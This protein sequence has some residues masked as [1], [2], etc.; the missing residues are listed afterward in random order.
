[1]FLFLWQFLLPLILFVVA[2]WKI[3]G[4]VRRQGKVATRRRATVSMQPV[5]EADGGKTE[6]PEDG[7]DKDEGVNSGSA[8]AG[9]T[10]RSQVCSQRKSSKTLSKTQINVVSTMVN[11]TIGFTVCWMPTY[12]CFIIWTLKVS[13]IPAESCVTVIAYRKHFLCIKQHTNRDTPVDE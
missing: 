7:I 2:Y 5:A 10:G 1:M 4:V 9:L 6:M 13:W 3:W 12:I 11:I 8:T